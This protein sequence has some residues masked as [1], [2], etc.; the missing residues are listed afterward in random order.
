MRR[1]LGYAII[2]VLAVCLTACGSTDMPKDAGK[3]QQTES[4]Q[5]ERDKEKPAGKDDKEKKLTVEVFIKKARDAASL[6]GGYSFKAKLETYPSTDRSKIKSMPIEKHYSFL[7]YAGQTSG[8][9]LELR[10]ENG[11][12]SDYDKTSTFTSYFQ[13]GGIAYKSMNGNEPEMAGETDDNQICNDFLLLLSSAPFEDKELGDRD[14]YELVQPMT[15]DVWEALGIDEADFGIDDIEPYLEDAA[16]TWV[17]D[18]KTKLPKSAEL[19]LLDLSTDTFGSNSIKFSAYFSEWGDI[20]DSD[21][22]TGD[23]NTNSKILTVDGLGIGLPVDMGSL[24]NEGW[25]AWDK[26][27]RVYNL[28]KEGFHLQALSVYFDSHDE[29]VGIGVSSQASFDDNT[30][31]VDFEGLHFGSSADDVKAVFGEPETD[32]DVYENLGVMEYKSFDING[33]S[34][35]IQF[36]FEDGGVSA[37]TITEAGYLG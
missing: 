36:L 28:V 31:D 37:I 9:V 26:G 12:T 24:I 6:A 1:K 4:R 20:E 7:S 11:R 10:I 14:E 32:T 18:A 27:S 21:I 3:P 15:K 23:T 35:D 5:D 16:L 2:P 17:F 8:N 25:Y 30:L 13:D 19:E 34:C 22:D 33:M 29:C